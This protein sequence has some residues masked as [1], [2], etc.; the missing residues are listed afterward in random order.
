MLTKKRIDN[1]LRL[2]FIMDDIDDELNNVIKDIWMYLIKE[3][4]ISVFSKTVPSKRIATGNVAVKCNARACEGRVWWA[5]IR[6]RN[7][8]RIIITSDKKKLWIKPG[9]R[10]KLEGW[11][12]EKISC[13]PVSKLAF[14]Q[15]THRRC[16]DTLMGPQD[17]W[18]SRPDS[19]WID[20]LERVGLG[21]NMVLTWPC[22][23][24]TN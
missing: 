22:D 4:N 3:L 11:K 1:S 19:V 21:D 20:N 5:R 7:T 18:E 17:S 15:C 12:L 9:R 16:F 24:L 2:Y 14:F 10:I 13:H 23:I 6:L 8:D